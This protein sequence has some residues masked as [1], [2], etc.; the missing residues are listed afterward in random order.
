MLEAVSHGAECLV[1]AASWRDAAPHFLQ[2]LGE[3]SGASRSY[4]FENGV[5]ED[6][7]LIA[8]QRFEW[9]AATT[10]AQL[11]NPVMQ[12]MCFEEVGLARVAELGTRNELF[13]SKVND[14]PSDERRFFEQQAIKSLMTV[15]IF[16]GGQ[17]WGFIGFDD[18]ATEREW[19][20]AE[21][22]A[23]RTSS[24]LIAAAIERELSEETL[25]EQEQ[26]LRAVFDMAL[27]AIYITDDERHFVDVNPAACEYYGVSKRDLVGRKVEDFLPPHRVAT[28][29]EDW[30][31][32]LEGGPIRAEWETRKIDGTIQVA[33]ASA[34][35]NFLPGLHIAFLRDITDRK[36]LE[37]SS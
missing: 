10:A 26:K 29:E 2:E 4:L 8:S 3:A 17:W 27:D 13:T 33:E 19:S 9:A 34:R 36:R 23:L 20:P 15:P 28:L 14:L 31:Q 35:P 24:S 18:C 6:G 12:D 32:Y 25:R 16:V 37:A 22:D 21:V 1:A 30:A 5:R 7:R 11:A